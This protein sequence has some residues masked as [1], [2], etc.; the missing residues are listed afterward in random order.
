MLTAHE[1][2]GFM[3]PPLAGQILDTAH[4]E[5]K[6][7]YRLALN[8]VAE[9]RKVR[10]IF[11]ARKS[12]VERHSDM[13]SMLSR[14]RLDLIAANLIRSWLVKKHTP[15]LVAFMESLG[16]PHKDGAVEDLPESVEDAKLDE[17]LDK[18][19]S[20]FP[21][22]EVAIYLNAFYSMNEVNWPNLKSKLETDPRL[23][24]GA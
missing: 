3:P 6:E 16:I 19:V 24:L 14:P 17:A 7:V 10:P 2:F 13:A 18:L 22:A 1:L 4:S 5:D 9:A 8:A 11:Y 15:M 23:Q 21:P 20:Q 12:R